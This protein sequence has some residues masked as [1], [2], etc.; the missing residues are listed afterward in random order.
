MWEDFMTQPSFWLITGGVH[1]VYKHP[2]VGLP[3]F[4]LYQIVNQSQRS[5]RHRNKGVKNVKSIWLWRESQ[6][7]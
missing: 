1:F 3:E 7:K 2:K 4:V 6:Q 5:K